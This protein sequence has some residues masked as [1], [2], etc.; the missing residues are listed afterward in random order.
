MRY[1][2]TTPVL[3]AFFIALSALL[4]GCSST[5]RASDADRLALYQA[6]AGEPVNN[7]RMFGRLNGWT[8]LGTSA[9]TVW[10]RPNEA[11]LLDVTPC[12]DLPFAQAITIS[13]FANTV[14]ARFDTVT[15]IGPGTTQNARFPCRITKIRPIDVK[16]LNQNRE[17]MRQAHTEERAQETPTEGTPADGP[18]SN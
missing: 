11:F 13:N 5:P 6:H 12:Q 1:R 10:T 14:T 8:P 7:F 17:E 4:A 2:L 9:L 3:P 16:A 15:P 18:S